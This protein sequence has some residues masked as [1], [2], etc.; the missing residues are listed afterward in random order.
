LYFITS[1][2]L[3]IKLQ[4]LA[5]FSAVSILSPVNIHT[6]ISILNSVYLLEVSHE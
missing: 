6:F 1:K 4:L 5:M 2:L 3:C